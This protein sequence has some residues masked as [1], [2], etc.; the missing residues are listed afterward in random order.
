MRHRDSGGGGGRRDRHTDRRRDVFEQS[1][2]RKGGERPGDRRGRDPT[3]DRALVTN[4]NRERDFNDLRSKLKKKPSFEDR[5]SFPPRV[6]LNHIEEEGKAKEDVEHRQLKARKINKSVLNSIVRQQANDNTKAKPQPKK[7]KEAKASYDDPDVEIVNTTRD[8]SKKFARTVKSKTGAIQIENDE[9]EIVSK[10]NDERKFKYRSDSESPV[11]EDKERSSSSFKSYSDETSS[12]YKKPP[13]TK[14]KKFTQ[15]EE[16]KK[17]R[18]RKKEQRLLGELL[19]NLNPEKI[20]SDPSITEDDLR[21]LFGK[22]RKRK[23]R[24]QKKSSSESSSSSNSDSSDSSSS[25]DSEEE[26]SKSENTSPNQSCQTE[27]NDEVERVN[28]TK[29]SFEEESALKNARLNK[30][31]QRQ[32]EASQPSLNKSFKRQKIKDEKNEFYVNSNPAIERKF[33]NKVA[34]SR[35]VSIY[36]RKQSGDRSFNDEEARKQKLLNKSWQKSK[37]TPTVSDIKC[38]LGSMKSSLDPFNDFSPR[39]IMEDDPHP[40]SGE[41]RS[42]PFEPVTDRSKLRRHDSRERSF[43]IKRDSYDRRA[44]SPVDRRSRSPYHRR[45]RSRE[46]LKRSPRPDLRSRSGDVRRVTSSSSKPTSGDSIQRNSLHP[47]SCF[48]YVILFRGC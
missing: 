6:K 12:K 15:E 27:S 45:E 20:K 38:R 43:D 36:E 44:R 28:P 31:N 37:S 9:T 32:I 18:I 39:P 46:R 16:R 30:K 25:S 23:M 35:S 1:G 3:G 22:E 34:E 8:V 14:E 10:K 5:P 13:R 47:C 41:K 19:R 4:N 26:D 33:V 11:R 21:A 2:H 29:L 7:S 17:S 48:V 40:E 24:S 42:S